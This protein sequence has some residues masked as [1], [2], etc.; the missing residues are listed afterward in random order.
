MPAPRGNVLAL[1]HG[2]RT[3]AR[4]RP[5]A[6]AQRRR[7]LR[8]IGLRAS[9][10]D[11]LGRAL[12]AN[13]SRAAAA[14]SLMDDY[15][16]EEGWLDGDGNPPGFAKLYVSMLNAE[17]HALRALEAHLRQT[18]DLD[19]L[20]LLEGE[21]RRVR[22]EAERRLGNGASGAEHPARRAEGRPESPA[23][24]MRGG[25]EGFRSSR[26]GVESEQAGGAA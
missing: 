7:L 19:P 20:G 17:R 25:G 1:R 23:D 3:E 26:Q 21:G 8:Q 15:T 14:L 22:L 6:R 13:W 4:I 11:G 9:D 2:A 24:G 5:V 16:A 12:L 18:A 10:L